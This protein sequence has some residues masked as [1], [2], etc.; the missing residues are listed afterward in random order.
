[1][2]GGDL[3][4]PR[5]VFQFNVRVDGDKASASGTIPPRITLRDVSVTIPDEAIEA[6]L[7]D[8]L[9]IGIDSLD[10]SLDA[11]QGFIYPV[12]VSLEWDAPASDTEGESPFWIETR[13][14]PRTR[15]SSSI[16]DFFLLP[17]QV[18][19]ENA[20]DRTSAGSLSWSGVYAVPVEQA[21]T[22]L[23]EH[24]L[25][26]FLLRGDQFFANF[27]TSRDNPERREPESNVVG[28]IGFVGG[29]SLDSLSLTVH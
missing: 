8:T 18:L 11:R 3:V 7:L 13:L 23:P 9:D 27:E 17:K 4:L 26:V 1:L 5:S 19:P 12:Q 21:T 24:G 14:E 20:V 25:Q 29:I 15:F 28:G 16:I 10:L 22:P 2:N 6:V